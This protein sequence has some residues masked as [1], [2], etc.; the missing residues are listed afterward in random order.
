MKQ[1][2]NLLKIRETAEKIKAKIGTLRLYG[3]LTSI[4]AESIL[5]DADAIIH[6]AV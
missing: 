6:E 4:E 2:T 5:H 3:Q 1:H